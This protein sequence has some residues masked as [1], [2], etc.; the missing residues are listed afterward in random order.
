MSGQLLKETH[1]YNGSA[2]ITQAQYGSFPI[3]I[4]GFASAMYLIVFDYDNKSSAVC[5]VLKED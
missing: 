5:K 2:G 1:Y 4:S 3:D